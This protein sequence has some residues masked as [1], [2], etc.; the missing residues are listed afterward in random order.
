LKPL[1]KC[2]KCEEGFVCLA[3]KESDEAKKKKKEKTDDFKIL[4]EFFCS[5]MLFL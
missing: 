5:I 3:K 2:E 4:N 1:Y